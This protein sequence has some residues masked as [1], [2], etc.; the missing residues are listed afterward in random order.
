VM[1]VT[2]RD[3]VL[4]FCQIG[5]SEPGAR[6]LASPSLVVHLLPRARTAARE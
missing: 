1:Q 3:R 5:L 6:E 4:P 2:P